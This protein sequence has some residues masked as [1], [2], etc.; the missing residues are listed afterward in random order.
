MRQAA[1]I[2]WIWDKQPIIVSKNVNSA[3]DDYSNSPFMAFLSLK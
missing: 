3:N 1:A 2:P